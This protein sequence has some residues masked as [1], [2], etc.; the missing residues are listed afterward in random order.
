MPPF[1]AH[2]A[3]AAQSVRFAQKADFAKTWWHT[4]ASGATGPNQPL[5]RDPSAALQLLRSMPSDEYQVLYMESGTTTHDLWLFRVDGDSFHPVPDGLQANGSVEIAGWQDLDHS[6]LSQKLAEKYGQWGGGPIGRWGAAPSVGSGEYRIRSASPLVGGYYK[7]IFRPVW[8]GRGASNSQYPE[9]Q[10]P[11]QD[12]ALIRQLDRL[13]DRVI[14]AAE[15]IE[16]TPGTVS[17]YSVA[18]RE[19]LILQCTEIET[20]LQ[21]LLIEHGQNSE[22]RN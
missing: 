13:T 10:V 14:E 8:N 21:N 18:L 17:T 16:P 1:A 4:G 5:T 2:A 15:F 3:W 7:K 20:I 9:L 11:F 6:T 22:S 19:T 12:Y